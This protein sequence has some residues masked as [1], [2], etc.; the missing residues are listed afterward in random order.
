METSF[1]NAGQVSPGYASPWA[2]PGI[3]LK[4]LGRD[5]GVSGRR[6]LGRIFI[7]ETSAGCGRN[8]LVDNGSAPAG[9]EHCHL[10]RAGLH[11]EPDRRR[12]SR[13]RVLRKTSMRR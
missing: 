1:G 13:G 12:H 5:H 3:P 11:S 8:Y 9:R 7:S 6:A 2:A 4:A 10:A